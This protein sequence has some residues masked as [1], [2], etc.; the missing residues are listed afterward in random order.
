MTTPRQFRFVLIAV[1]LMLTFA[2][3]QAS[4]QEGPTRYTV[5]PGETLFRIAL[6]HNV[7]VSDI[8]AANGITDVTHIYV[9]QV[10]VIPVSGQPVEQ[11]AAEQPQ[12]VAASQPTGEGVYH[13]VV[14]GESLKSIAN[15]YGVTWQQ[16]VEANNLANPNVIY[17]GQ[18]L[19]VPGVTSVPAS[20]A[21]AEQPAATGTRRHVVLAGEGLSQIA[22]KYGVTWTAI[23]AANNLANPDVIYS[24]MVLIIPE[25]GDASYTGN[26][27]AAPTAPTSSGKVILVILSQQ[28]TYAYEDGKLMRA[29]TVSTG[30]PATPTVTGEYSVYVKYAAQLMTGPGYYLP[31]VPYVM[32]FYRGYGLHGTY[33]HNNFG[34]PMSHGCVNLPTNE[35]EWFYNWAPVG[36]KVVVRW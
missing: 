34:H 10:L 32:Y 12:S 2:P 14:R 35:A 1:L 16:L 24:G 3:L 6:K 20:E 21:P 33:W 26:N 30:L 5:Q 31:N 36:T 17:V 27:Y 13:T 4:A 15:R 9:G 18:R 29:V 25:K 23:A 28:R 19:F 8:A 11:P 22:A 7:T